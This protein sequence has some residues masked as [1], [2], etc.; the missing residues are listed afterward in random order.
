MTVTIV[1]D[2]DRGGSLLHGEQWLPAPL[3]VV[4]AFFADASRLEE[5]T[6]ASLSFHVE[7][8]GPIEMVAGTLIDYRLR[9]HGI[10]LRWR[11]EITVWEP[12]LRF[13]DVQ[14]IG[15]Y[16]HW[17]HEH[18]FRAADGGTLVGDT[19][20]YAVPGGSLVNRLFVKRDLE[21]IFA[22]RQQVLGEHFAVN[23]QLAAD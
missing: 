16:R 1:P 14:R 7:T 19:V 23:E 18:T 2:A 17:E 5:I 12:P 4:F 8:P 13:V 10:P 11:S 9:V 22:H 15:P 21:R 20:H 3:E 6:P